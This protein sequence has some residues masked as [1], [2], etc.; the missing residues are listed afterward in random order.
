MHVHDMTA[1]WAD[2]SVVPEAVGSWAHN[3]I[4]V[5]AV[6]ELIGFHAGQLVVFDRSGRVSRSANSDWQRVCQTGPE[7]STGS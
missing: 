4:A 6:G 5:T 7:S 3:G 2:L 1:D